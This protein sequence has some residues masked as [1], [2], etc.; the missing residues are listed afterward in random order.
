[1]KVYR[2]DKTGFIIP[3]QTARNNRQSRAYE[4][5]SAYLEGNFSLFD[6]DETEF[7]KTLHMIF[8]KIPPHGL[9]FVLLSF[10]LNRRLK[11]PPNR[12]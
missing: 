3:C 6:Y 5:A 9:M 10:E 12:V 1:M 8:S 2:H 4:S 7:K 11:R